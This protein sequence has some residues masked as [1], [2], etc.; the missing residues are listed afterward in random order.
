MNNVITK[1]EDNLAVNLMESG[2][3]FV[4]L[5][6]KTQPEKTYVMLLEAAAMQPDA[7]E[8]EARPK[9]W[10]S[11]QVA[12]GVCLPYAGC[13]GG[14]TIQK[15][16]PLWAR[17]FPKD[18]KAKV[19]PKASY[20]L[21][22]TLSFETGREAALRE[23]HEETLGVLRKYMRK[24]ADV[25]LKEFVVSGGYTTKWE[26][27]TYRSRVT[28]VHVNIALPSEKELIDVLC[29]F[30]RASVEQLYEARQLYE[31]GASKERYWK[32]RPEDRLMHIVPG[33]KYFVALMQAAKQLNGHTSNGGGNAHDGRVAWLDTWPDNLRPVALRKWDTRILAP[34][35]MP[36][37]PSHEHNSSPLPFYIEKFLGV[38][39]DQKVY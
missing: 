23:L 24:D 4:T 25:V 37:D 26:G 11:I 20:T 16:D 18:G 8:G 15:D 35:Y 30:N 3:A 32:R 10:G 1:T 38:R 31:E 28:V 2:L 29:D 19:N 39:P 5:Q 36:H 7:P 33:D 14:K 22:S 34:L 21:E 13:V 6:L 12:D 27:E 17:L 9:I